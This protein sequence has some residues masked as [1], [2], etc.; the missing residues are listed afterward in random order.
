MSNLPTT[1]RTHFNNVASTHH[2][3]FGPLIETIT[4]EIKDRH[5]WISRRLATNPHHEHLGESES[6]QL[7]DYACGAGTATKSMTTGPPPI[8][9]TAIGLDLSENMVAGYNNWARVHGCPG[10][11]MRRI[12]LIY[13]TAVQLEL[14]AWGSL[15]VAGSVGGCLEPG[16]VCVVVDG[17]PTPTPTP[18][19]DMET[20]DLRAVLLPEQLDVLETINKHG[21]TEEEMRALYQG[22]GLG[23]N[24]EYEV[25]KR[26]LKFTMF[27]HWFSRRGFIARGEMTS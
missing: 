19:E 16:G 15:T 14:M 23:T 27:G 22:A 2:T 9:N 17:V 8:H 20:A 13:L 1:N 25:I 18:G 5:T 21:F 12:V 6:I 10:E 3:N 11:K 4:E 7:L 26:P 24:F